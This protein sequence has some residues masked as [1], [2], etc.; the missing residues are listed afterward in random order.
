MTQP[1][2]QRTAPDSGDVAEAFWYLLYIPP[3]NGDKDGKAHR[4]CS[5]DPNIGKR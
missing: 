1:P 4:R 3:I 2:R 5:A